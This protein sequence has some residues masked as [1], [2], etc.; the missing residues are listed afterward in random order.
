MGAKPK[1]DPRLVAGEEK[2]YTVAGAT[3]FQGHK[4]GETFKAALSP[5][6]EERALSRGSIVEGSKK[7]EDIQ[8]KAELVETAKSEGV[9]VPEIPEKESKAAVADAIRNNE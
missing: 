1:K 2:T 7:L 6:Q 4:P 9:P 5:A 8:T 3:R